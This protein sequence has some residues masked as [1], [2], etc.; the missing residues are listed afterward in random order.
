MAGRTEIV[1]MC[2]Y[3]AAQAYT[4]LV[5]HYKAL[6]KQTVTDCLYDRG[7]SKSVINSSELSLV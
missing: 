6:V 4:L 1:I 5:R 7:H 2:V 3:A